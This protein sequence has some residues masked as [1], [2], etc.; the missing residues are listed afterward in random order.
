MF[1]FIRNWQTI[2][3]NH[4]TISHFHQQYMKDPGSL[5]SCLHLLLFILISAI[6]LGVQ[7]HFTAVLIAFHCSFNLNLIWWLLMLNTF[8]CFYLPSLCPLQWVECL[9]TSFFFFFNLNCFVVFSCW[10]FE[11][12]YIFQILD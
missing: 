7:W 10:A 6:L 12:F 8:P 9:L 1:S 2:S 3:L 4:Y 11:I 5:S